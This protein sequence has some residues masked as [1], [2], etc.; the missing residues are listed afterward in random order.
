MADF[1]QV[2]ELTPDSFDKAHFMRARILA[3]DARFVDARE[4]LKRYTAKVPTDPAAQ[5]LLLQLSD[6]E[7]A[8]T[9]LDGALKAKLWTACEEAATTA[10]VVAPHAVAIRRKRAHC[11][12]AAGDYEQAIGDLSRLT[13][14]TAPSASDFMRIFRL[15]YFYLPPPSIQAMGAIKQCLHR[16]PDSKPC[17]TAHR[18]VKKLDKQFAK[19]DALMNAEDWRG[20]VALVLGSA[21]RDAS[22]AQPGDGMLGALEE[23]LDGFASPGMFELPHGL[24]L[25]AARRAS[26]RR[27]IVL[28]A[29]CRANAQLGQARSGERWADE[30]LRMLGAEQ[31]IDALM[32]KGDALLAREEWEE[33]VRIFERAWQASGGNREIRA[34]LSKAQRLL[35]LSKQKDYYKVLGVS[36]DADAKTIK[37]AYRKAVMK[38]HPDKGGSEAKMATVNEAYEVLSKPELRARFD[39]G[40][41]PNDPMA[42]AG[43]GGGAGGNPFAHFF[44][45]SGG[46]FHQG[47]G[48][49][50]GGFQ[51][52]FS[53]FH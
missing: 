40:D 14:I 36:R 44:Q 45:Q 50:G 29:L 2:L 25:P 16:D 26:P 34:R 12:L 53:G 15:A 31:E 39:N 32:A 30:L 42:G 51:F 22:P 37:K 4:A 27:I 43:P 35:K 10:L 49:G 23:A 19:L 21:S 48:G 47:G 18:L 52:H 8:A 41:D 46:P 28:R 20:I 24:A 33:A 9:K 7:A 13:H 3:K 11:A 38:A 17:L 6:A 1:D 5:D